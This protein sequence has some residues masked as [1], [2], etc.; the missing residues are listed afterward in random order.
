MLPKA[1]ATD[2][3]A[4][5]GAGMV[6]NA[7]SADDDFTQEGNSRSAEGQYPLAL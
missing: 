1:L 5:A 6:T 4:M 7:I 2:S 3:Q